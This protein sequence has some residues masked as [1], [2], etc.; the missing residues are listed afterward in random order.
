M[1][2]NEL[3]AL[4]AQ[5]DAL[6]ESLR[7]IMVHHPHSVACCDLVEGGFVPDLEKCTCR[8]WEI[9]ARKALA[10]LERSEP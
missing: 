4:L 7:E 8:D 5:R 1:S 3:P 2:D 9:R 6:A 10:A